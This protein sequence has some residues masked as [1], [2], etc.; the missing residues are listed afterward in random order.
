MAMREI[1]FPFRVDGQGRISTT[2]D[3][4]V[5]ARQHLTTYLL[6]QPGERVMRPDFGTPI[7]DYVFEN[8]DPLQ[9]QLLASRS[10]EKVS[11]DVPN[12]T[13]H[14]ISATADSA[15]S[16]VHLAVQ[17]AMAVG[18]STGAV[19]TTTISIGGAP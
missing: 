11:R 10:A 5:A 17:F 13:L 18:N 2:S 1:S 3:P 9:M 14:S 16:A 19:S 4:A 15:Q 7:R 8:L 6:T 12:V